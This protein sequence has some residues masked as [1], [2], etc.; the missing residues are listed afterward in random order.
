MNPVKLGSK[1]LAFHINN[2]CFLHH[3]QFSGASVICRLFHCLPNCFIETFLME[4]NLMMSFLRPDL[5]F[6]VTYCD[7]QPDILFIAPCSWLCRIIYRDAFASMWCYLTQIHLTFQ[8]NSLQC[9]NLECTF[10]MRQ[11]SKIIFIANCN[12]T[13]GFIKIDKCYRLH[14]FFYL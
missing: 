10:K 6:F 2:S 11:V 5:F 14:Y 13:C 7:R 3:M 1:I 8:Q 9:M 4:R 12:F